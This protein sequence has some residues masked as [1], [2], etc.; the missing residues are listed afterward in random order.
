[1]SSFNQTIGIEAVRGFQNKLVFGGAII[2]L[3]FSNG[4]KPCKQI[5]IFNQPAGSAMG[6]GDS[7]LVIGGGYLLEPG[8]RLTLFLDNP[9]DIRVYAVSGFC[10]LSYFVH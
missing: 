4:R 6:V 2:S 9:S 7:S 1:M 5:S 10:V 3:P 8:K